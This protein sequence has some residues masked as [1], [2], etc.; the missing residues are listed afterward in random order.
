M[1]ERLSVSL[2]CVAR[3]LVWTA[4]WTVEVRVMVRVR[5]VEACVEETRDNS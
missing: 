3:V 1:R 5:S 2:V 4:L